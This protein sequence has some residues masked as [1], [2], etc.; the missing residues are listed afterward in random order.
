MISVDRLA[1]LH[2]AL[3][4]LACV[5]PVYLPIFARIDAELELARMAADPVAKA[6]AL[7][8]ALRAVP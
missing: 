1:R 7:A 5:D 2:A 3:A 8:A 6:R 4:E